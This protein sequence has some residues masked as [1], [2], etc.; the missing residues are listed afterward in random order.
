[1]K[2]LKGDIS[3]RP[4]ENIFRVKFHPNKYP[5]SSR[6]QNYFHLRGVK[7]N[8]V[9]NVLRG[10]GISENTIKTFLKGSHVPSSYLTH[11]VEEI[12]GIRF[13]SEDFE[14]VKNGNGRE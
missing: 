8:T 7:Y 12:W 10:R 3:L 4:S 1:M 6:L 14:E 5:Y 11:L 9:I 13:A 2:N